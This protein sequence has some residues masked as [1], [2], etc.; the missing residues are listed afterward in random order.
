VFANAALFHVPSEALPRVLLELRATL[1]PRGVCCSARP[2]AAKTRKVGTA[3]ATV[4]T[5]ISRPGAVAY[6]LPA[7]SSRHTTTALPASRGNSS[8]GW[9][10]SGAGR[11][12]RLGRAALKLVRGDPRAGAFGS[13]ELRVGVG[14]GRSGRPDP[15]HAIHRTRYRSATPSVLIATHQFCAIEAP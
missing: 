13:T 6:R 7:S 9:P 11:K 14:N 3:G 12:P 2:H 15:P 4:C 1:K 5:M 8:P 10:G